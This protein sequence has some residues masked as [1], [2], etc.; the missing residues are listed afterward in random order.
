[1]T[2]RFTVTL[3]QSGTTTGVTGAAMT[4]TW[5]NLPTTTV[6][7][8]WPYSVNAPTSVSTNTYT[9]TSTKTLTRGNGRGCKLTLNSVTKAGFVLDP[10]AVLS[11]SRTWT[12]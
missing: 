12:T 3:V 10:A 4:A 9:F 6:A 11:F 7:T 5:S 2:C 8:G 1:M